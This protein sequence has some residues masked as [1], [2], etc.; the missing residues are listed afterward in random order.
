MN[1]ASPN[2]PVPGIAGA[3]LQDRAQHR[4]IPID[5]RVREGLVDPFALLVLAGFVADSAM[6]G[7]RVTCKSTKMILHLVCIYTKRKSI[8][9]PLV[10]NVRT[11]YLPDFPWN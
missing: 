11:R 8:G 9:L 4:E 3:A 5:R 2:K 1:R 6:L 10:S 7:E